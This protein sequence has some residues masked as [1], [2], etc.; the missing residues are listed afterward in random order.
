MKFTAAANHRTI[1][2]GVGMKRAIVLLAFVVGCGDDSAATA[3]AAVDASQID[4]AIDAPAIDGPGGNADAG[5]LCPASDGGAAGMHKLFLNFE[6]GFTIT[7]GAGACTNDATQNCSFIAT[8]DTPIMQFDAADA[9]RAQLLADIVSKMNSQLAPYSVE[10]TTTR[11]ASG[12]YKMIV[13]AQCAT[14]LMCSAGSG[15]IGPVECPPNMGSLNANDIAFVFEQTG[16]NAFSYANN[17]LFLTGL[18]NGLSIN[19]QQNDCMC[20]VCGSTTQLC[21]YS[22]DVTV[23]M[24]GTCLPMGS[25]YN[26]QSLLSAALGCR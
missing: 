8:A 2:A 26:E 17:A 12:P 6:G 23:D 25:H 3:D 22:T 21:S 16:E 7:H 5:P 1:G 4:A 19:A 18:M 24:N 11:P 15:S 13:F 10:V 20:H 9:N 14:A